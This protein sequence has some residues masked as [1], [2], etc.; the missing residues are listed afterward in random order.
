MSDDL[1]HQLPCGFLKKTSKGWMRLDRD[2]R[3]LIVKLA[4]AQK[5]RCAFCDRTKGLIVE[6][7]HSPVRG[8]GDKPTI[9]NVRGLA[10]HR[11]NWHLGMY[12][13]DARGDYLAWNDVYIRISECDFDPYNYAYECRV[14][15]LLENELEQQLEPRNYWRRRQFLQKFDDWNEWGRGC[16]PWRSYFAEI[17]ERQRR[18][19]RTPEQFWNN[20]ADIVRFFIEQRQKNPDA[21]LPDSFAKLLV[22]LKPILDNARPIIEERYREIQ[23]SQLT[24]ATDLLPHR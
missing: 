8:S 19:I 10:C 24:I 1:W 11:C 2:L 17:K 22:R 5:F 3:L 20:L 13:A 23:A 12:E 7:D 18:K 21:E 4:S 15:T 14:L 16:Y 6:H 9:Y